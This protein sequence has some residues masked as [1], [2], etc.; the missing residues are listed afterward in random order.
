MDLL[1][2]SMING[3]LLIDCAVQENIELRIIN[4]QCAGEDWRSYMRILRGPQYQRYA[5]LK[6]VQRETDVTPTLGMIPFLL[7]VL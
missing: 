1:Q 4:R 3:M 2:R 7:A 5:K 6:I